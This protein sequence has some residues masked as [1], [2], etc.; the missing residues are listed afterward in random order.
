MKFILP[1]KVQ[2]VLTGNSLGSYDSSASVR[3]YVDFF[4]FIKQLIDTTT[5]K[6]FLHL[7]STMRLISHTVIETL[8]IFTYVKMVIERFPSPFGLDRAFYG[9][10]TLLSSG[11]NTHPKSPFKY[12]WITSIIVH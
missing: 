4:I 2:A 11:W 12:N 9:K 1:L 6:P 10:G 7:R 5:N 8:K 3:F